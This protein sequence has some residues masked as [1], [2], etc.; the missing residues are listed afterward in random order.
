MIKLLYKIVK[1]SDGAYTS[2]ERELPFFYL[3]YD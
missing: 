1:T 2:V 3:S